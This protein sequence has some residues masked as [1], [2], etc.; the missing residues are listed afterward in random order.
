M[1][2]LAL[3]AVLLVAP[4]CLAT[5]E[6]LNDLN[7]EL[8]AAQAAAIEAKL[9]AENPDV[10]QAELDAAV[11]AA[12]EAAKEAKIAAGAIGDAV[13]ADAKALA[14]EV[15]GL[16]GFGAIGDGGL[17]AFILSIASWFLRDRRKRHGMDPLQR[18]DIMTPPVVNQ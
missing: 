7:V 15:K 10:T 1:K 2:H 3:A 14:D 4:G 13:K 12:I 11:A 6:A 17:V 16:T 9:K 5:Q 8:Q 18:R